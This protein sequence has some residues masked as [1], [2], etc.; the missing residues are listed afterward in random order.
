MQTPV[1]EGVVLLRSGAPR[2]LVAAGCA[3]GKIMLVD[4]RRK[5]QVEESITAH[6]GGLMALDLSGSTLATS[7]LGTRQGQLVQDTIVKVQAS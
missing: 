5:F 3:S 7:G 4:P 2:G 6:T 1:S